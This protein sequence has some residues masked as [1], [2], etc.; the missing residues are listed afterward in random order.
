MNAAR[1]LRDKKASGHKLLAP[2]LCAGYPAPGATL[3]LLRAAADAGADCIELGVPFS[4]PLADGGV[5]QEAAQVALRGGMTLA[6]AL[7][8]AAAF[9]A[10]RPEVPLFLMSYANPLL[11]MGPEAF[12]ARAAAAGVVGCIVPDLPPEDQGDFVSAGAPPLVQFAAPNT[13]DA[14]VCEVATLS[15][16]FLYCVSVLGVTGAR[17]DVAPETVAFL[18][19]VRGLTHLP[20]LAGFGVGTPG[21]AAALAAECDGVIVGSALARALEGRG[22]AEWAGA[23][24]SFLEPMRRALDGAGKE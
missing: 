8:E 7:D 19:R 3:P 15:P 16:P 22:P 17:Q 2:Y 24:R 12:A 11:R 10:E 1:A 20:A 4:D 23:A 5:L 13:P 6:R 14:R 9:T 18:R 21:H